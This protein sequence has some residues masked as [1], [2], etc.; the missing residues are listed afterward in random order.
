MSPGV[1]LKP[2]SGS[3]QLW[4]SGLEAGPLQASAFFSAVRRQC[5][6]AKHLILLLAVGNGCCYPRKRRHLKRE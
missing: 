5:L 6:G 2:S 3:E 4:D 1:T